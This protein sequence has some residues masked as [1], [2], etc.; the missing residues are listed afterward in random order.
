MKKTLFAIMVAMLTIAAQAA[1]LNWC[2]KSVTFEGTKLKSNTGV[3]GYLIYLSTAALEDSYA[4]TKATTAESLADEIGSLVTSQNKTT[5]VSKLNNNYDFVVGDT[6]DNGDA[7]A[8]L[9]TYVVDGNTYYNLSNEIYTM[10]GALADPPTDPAEAA[11]TF[12]YGTA[13][14]NGSLSSGAGWTKVPEPAS[15]MLALAGV[16]MLIRRRK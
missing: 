3:T 6:Y 1:T 5:A 2:A 12:N 16:A 13:E 4:I 15:A 8:M 7:F 11:F 9:L 10:S 14:K